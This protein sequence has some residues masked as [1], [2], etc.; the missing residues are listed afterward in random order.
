ML[1][2]VSFNFKDT[3]TTL[4]EMGVYDVL[5]PF[6]LIFAIVF[7]TLEKTKVLGKDKTNINAL[8]SLVIGLLLVVQQTIVQTINSFLPR[9]SLI[10]VVILMFLLIISMIAGKEFK[11]LQGTFL[12]FAIIGVIISLYFAL[13]PS[14]DISQETRDSLLRIGLP[15]IIFLALM[16]F[17]TGGPKKPD[18][19]TF[20]QKL[21]NALST[22]LKGDK[23]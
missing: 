8:V 13:S 9:V 7:A 23:D 2:Q 6:L 15:L 18:D 10:I 11:G 3:I 5:L 19:K 4:Q 12:T 14:T 20:F 22:G 16:F 1:F 17:I 21:D